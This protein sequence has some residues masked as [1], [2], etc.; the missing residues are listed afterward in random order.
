MKKL[1]L[2]AIAFIGM[3]AIAQ[4]A[5]KETPRNHDRS[6]KMMNLSAEEIATLQTKKMT[7][8]LD[9]NKSQQAK[10]QKM[11]FENATKRKEMMANFKAKKESGELKKPT[12]EDRFKMKNAKLDHQIAMKAKMKDILNEEQFAK[13]EKGQ[14]RM[15]MKG[16]QKK[17]D[18]KKRK[19]QKEQK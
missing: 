2:I 11:N 9:L 12:D 17:H 19:Y 3:Q 1:I 13:W 5:P 7:L 14:M 10:I 15:A 6:K 16:K 18:M 8:H 4:D